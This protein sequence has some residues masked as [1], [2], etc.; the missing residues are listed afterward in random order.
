MYSS[1]TEIGQNEMSVITWNTKK[2]ANGFEFKVIEVGYQVPTLMLKTGKC[3]TRAI[4]ANRA[5]K[6]AR[7]LKANKAA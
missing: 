6:W 3:R 2:I 1:T 5:K 7:F 4:A